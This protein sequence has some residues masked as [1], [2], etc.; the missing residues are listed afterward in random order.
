MFIYI[1]VIEKCS[2]VFNQDVELQLNT[3]HIVSL[4]FECSSDKVKPTSKQVLL[5]QFLHLDFTTVAIL[6]LRPSHSAFNM[7][8]D[9]FVQNFNAL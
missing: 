4:T 3:T 1:S 5:V 2:A 7:V 8:F 6:K 9:V